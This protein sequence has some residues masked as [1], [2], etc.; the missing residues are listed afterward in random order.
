VALE[1]QPRQARVGAEVGGGADVDLGVLGRPVLSLAVDA[2]HE[3]AGEEQQR[4]DD[5]RARAEPAAAL[6]RPGHVGARDRD[7]GGL[8]RAEAAAV[9]EQASELEEVAAGV[10][11]AG[12]AAHQHDPDLGRVGLAEGRADAVLDH[13]EHDGVYPEVATHAETHVRVALAGPGQR[14]G[15]VVLEVP[16]GE[17]HER[18]RDDVG[19]PALDEAVDGEVGERLGHLDEAEVDR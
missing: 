11:V 3:H 2:R 5:D 8:D 17:Q 16:G 19:L 15:P 10:G 6:Q 4:R 1:H 7:E 14:G 13:G 9:G 12:A 18:D